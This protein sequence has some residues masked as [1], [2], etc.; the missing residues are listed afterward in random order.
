MGPPHPAGASGSSN[1]VVPK[2]GS[3][4]VAPGS[5]E[6][7]TGGQTEGLTA[8][9]LRRRRQAYFDRQEN[10]GSSFLPRYLTYETIV[11]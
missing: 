11:C 4:A 8:E 3:A 6:R 1:P 5:T 9:E 2:E 7:T 10:S